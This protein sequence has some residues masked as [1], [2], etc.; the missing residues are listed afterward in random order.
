MNSVLH[1][2]DRIELL[3]IQWKCEEAFIRKIILLRSELQYYYKEARSD[4][5]KI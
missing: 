5:Q 4:F 1:V 2:C 3:W